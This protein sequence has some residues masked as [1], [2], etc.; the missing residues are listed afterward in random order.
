VWLRTK[1][2]DFMKINGYGRTDP[3]SFKGVYLAAPAT[4]AKQR[5]RTLEA[6]VINGVE[7]LPVK[8]LKNLLSKL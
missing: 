3:I 7:Q 1:M 5:F 8:E 6:E 4:P 2:R